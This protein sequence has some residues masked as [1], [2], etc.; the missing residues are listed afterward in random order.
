MVLGRPS[1]S[2]AVPNYEAFKFCIVASIL[3]E[4]VFITPYLVDAGSFVPLLF[5]LVYKGAPRGT[6]HFWSLG[7][8]LTRQ[9]CRVIKA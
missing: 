4:M 2:A 6:D 5:L 9:R 1:N 7:F 8:L 3:F